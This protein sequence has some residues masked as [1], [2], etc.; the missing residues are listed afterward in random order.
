MELTIRAMLP[1]DWPAVRAIYME[2]IASGIS[3]FEVEAPDWE[4]WDKAHRQNC[5]LVAISPEN[6]ILGWAALSQTSKRPAYH[7]VAEVSIY[8]GERA[9]GKGVGKVLLS[10]LVDESELDGIWTLQAGIMAVNE[11]SIRLHTACGFRMVGL[12][13][14]VSKMNGI[15]HD[16]VLMERRSLIVGLD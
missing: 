16:T 5:R 10:R 2:G 1:D 4:N 8:I 14:R 6:Q 13:E 9:R 11:A 3:T 12:R 7:G 15:W